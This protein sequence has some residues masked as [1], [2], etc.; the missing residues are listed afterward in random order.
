[1]GN[2]AKR[3]EASKLEMRRQSF[4]ALSIT[5]RQ[6]RKRPG[7]MNSHKQGNPGTGKHR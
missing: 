4:D 2:K 5:D 6:G 1:M 7:S 3:K